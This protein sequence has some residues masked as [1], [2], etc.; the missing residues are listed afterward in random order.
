M[1][2]KA[3]GKVPWIP[4][5]LTGDGSPCETKLRFSYHPTQAGL[6]PASIPASTGTRKEIATH[7]P[8]F[9]F[10][11]PWKEASLA[12]VPR[13]MVVPELLVRIRC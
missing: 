9:F 7:G 8:F 3:V 6:V 5:L 12:L 2:E 13:S 4:A 11:F 1:L 10:F